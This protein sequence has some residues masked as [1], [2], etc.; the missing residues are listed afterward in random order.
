MT[1]DDPYASKILYY[2]FQVSRLLNA[3]YCM[4]IFKCPRLFSIIH[5]CHDDPQ[6]LILV[7]LKDYQVSVYLQNDFQV[8]VAVYN[9]PK[10][11]FQ[12]YDDPEVSFQVYD[13]FQVS[14]QTYDDSEVFVLIN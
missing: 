3:G 5:M 10:M 4:M 14:Y 13:D 11:S 7:Y 6:V 8:F 12:V 2:A 9:H 1:N